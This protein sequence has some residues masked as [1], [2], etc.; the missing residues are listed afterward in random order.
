[1]SCRG[2]CRWPVAVRP[3]HTQQPVSGISPLEQIPLGQSIP[4]IR[5]QIRAN[6]K[7]DNYP[8]FVKFQVQGVTV[9]ELDSAEITTKYYKYETADRANCEKFSDLYSLAAHRSIYINT[10]YWLPRV[11]SKSAPGNSFFP[12]QPLFNNFIAA[13]PPCWLVPFSN[14]T[15]LCAEHNTQLFR[16]LDI[17]NILTFGKPNSR[18]LIYKHT[19]VT[20]VHTLL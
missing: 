3:L 7:S 20:M 5:I 17:G 8:I 12:Q 2:F 9:L 15:I 14:T 4:S 10:L 6:A 19:I 13:L 11:M 16:S 18:L 1:M